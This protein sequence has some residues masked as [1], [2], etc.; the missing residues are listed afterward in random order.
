MPGK[1][2]YPRLLNFAEFFCRLDV[3]LLLTR[4]QRKSP[5]SRRQGVVGVWSEFHYTRQTDSPVHWY[6]LSAPDGHNSCRCSRH[7]HSGS[8]VRRYFHSRG[9]PRPAPP[10]AKR[11]AM[12]LKNSPLAFCITGSPKPLPM[13]QK[14][15]RS[16]SVSLASRPRSNTKPLPLANSSLAL[17]SASA[18]VCNPS[19]G[20]DQWSSQAESSDGKASAMS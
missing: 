16:R 9:Y 2:R 6:P 1:D 4:V 3:T 11:S 5:A 14:T 17:C 15:R 18:M 7:H 19:A 12:M 20:A 13:I 10:P 8:A